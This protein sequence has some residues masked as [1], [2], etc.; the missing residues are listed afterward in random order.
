MASHFSPLQSTDEQ[1][2][3]DLFRRFGH[4]S[5]TFLARDPVT[6]RSRGF[7]FVSY[8]RKE[9]AQKALDTLNGRGFNNLILRVEWAKPRD[10]STPKP[11]AP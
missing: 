9:D 7:A 8:T 11:Q 6:H 1:D 10:F 4:T 3:M 2:L 5:R